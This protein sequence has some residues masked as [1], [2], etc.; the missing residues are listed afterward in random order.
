MSTKRTQ[1]VVLRVADLGESD[2]I[3][4][5][6]SLQ[7]GKITGIGKGAKKSRKRFSNKLE[8]F[9]LLDV[10]YDD[11]SRSG[12]VR[13]AEAELLCPFISL[14]EHYDRYV[15]GVLAC[16]L[17]YYWSRDFDADR[18]IYNL[19]VW[20][21]QKIDGGKSPR[22]VHIFFQVKLYAFLGYRPDLSGCLK[23]GMAEQAGMP[24]MFHHSRHGLL[25]RSCS[26]PAISRGTSTLS[27]NTIKLLQHAQD[28]PMEK[29]DRLRFSEASIH[30]ALMLFK[31]YGQYLLQREIKAWDFL[32]KSAE[33]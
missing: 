19:L 8:I 10:Y 3:V 28:L 21:L 31:T 27:M 4:T 33:A 25:C 26:P 15:G 20:A 5:F 18:N 16:E 29:L 7:S 22:L 24:Y 1:A 17:V 12:L 23:C 13:I 32:E 6:Y 2:K 9:S 14:R 11:R 30:E